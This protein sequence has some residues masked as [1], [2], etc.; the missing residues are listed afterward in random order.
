[1]GLRK[2]RCAGS[3]WCG[4]AA[5]VLESHWLWADVQVEGGVEQDARR[6]KQNGALGGSGIAAREEST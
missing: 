5:E 6:G 3:G 1:M 4:S 2:V